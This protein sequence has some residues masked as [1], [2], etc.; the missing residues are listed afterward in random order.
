MNSVNS[1]IPEIL[2]SYKKIAVVGISEKIYRASNGV[3]RIMMKNGYT[4][5]PVNPNYERVLGLQ[6]FNSLS[7][8]KGGVE[9]VN[10][11]RRSD[12]VLPVVEEAVKIKAKV[13]WMQLGVI[14][15]QAAQLALDAGLKVVMDRCI[16]IEYARFL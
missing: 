9:I 14:N 7:E 10:I 11:F 3:S 12:K 4:I 2:K 8:V 16:Q 6:C 13:V 15:E 1:E 5:I